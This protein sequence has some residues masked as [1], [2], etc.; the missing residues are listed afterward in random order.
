MLCLARIYP[1][2]D[3]EDTASASERKQ[4]GTTTSAGAGA[5]DV[6][7]HPEPPGESLTQHDDDDVEFD[8]EDESSQMAVTYV[9]HVLTHAAHH[10]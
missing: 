9:T 2:Q 8:P 5:S 4:I 1:I 10:G 7:P 3:V 6:D